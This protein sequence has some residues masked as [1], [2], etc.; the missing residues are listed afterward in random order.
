M[1]RQRLGDIRV[2]WR[3]GSRRVWLA[4]WESAR[5]GA[6]FQ[7]SRRDAIFLRCPVQGLK[8]LANLSRPCGTKASPSLLT[9]WPWGL[10]WETALFLVGGLKCRQ[11]VS[12]AFSDAPSANPTRRGGCLLGWAY[13]RDALGGLDRDLT[14]TQGKPWAMFYRPVGPK[15]GSTSYGASSGADTPLQPAFYRDNCLNGISSAVPAGPNQ[16]PALYP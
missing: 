9:Q 6:A 1:G 13:G 12:R 5:H 14:V 11:K 7:A 8:S 16:Y 10:P 4:V 2:F 15:T 3:R